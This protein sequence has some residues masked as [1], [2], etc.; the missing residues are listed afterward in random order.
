MHQMAAIFDLT[1]IENLKIKNSIG[2]EFST[3][4]HVKMRYYMVIYVK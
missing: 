2:N 3:K 4:N 1:F